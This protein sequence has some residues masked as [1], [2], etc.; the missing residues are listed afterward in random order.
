MPRNKRQPG[1]SRARLIFPFAAAGVL[2]ACVGLWMRG[3]NQGHTVSHVQRT[4]RDIALAGAA[5][6]A[7]LEAGTIG[8]W[9]IAAE[10]VDPITGEYNEF[11]LGAGRMLITAERA[12][13]MVDPEADTF[14]FDMW[15]VVYTRVPLPNEATDESYV[16]NLDR[17][18][19]GPAPY[20]MDIIA[21][22]AIRTPA[23]PV[24]NSSGIVSA[25]RGPDG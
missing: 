11:R 22:S 15:N 25:D 19:L 7:P 13:L 3:A 4:V 2:V 6:G 10:H 8:P 1:R 18:V 5:T 14:S 21:D 16:W 12:V 23:L 17:Y 24:P 9:K 20:G